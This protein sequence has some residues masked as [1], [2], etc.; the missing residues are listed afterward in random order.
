ME[1]IQIVDFYL[2][3]CKQYCFRGGYTLLSSMFDKIRE[4]TSKCSS[5]NATRKIADICDK[6]TREHLNSLYS[7]IRLF[8]WN[9][10]DEKTLR[11]KINIAL[12]EF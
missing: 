4:D 1:P 5:E 8:D 12:Q 6:I 3:N 2:E 7:K 11:E 9:F 10:C